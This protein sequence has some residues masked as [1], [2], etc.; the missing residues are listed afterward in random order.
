M[1]DLISKIVATYLS[2]YFAA[3]S[4]VMAIRTFHK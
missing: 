4:I 2:L 3:L 1:I